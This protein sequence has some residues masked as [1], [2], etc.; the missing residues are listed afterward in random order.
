LTRLCTELSG[1]DPDD[2]LWG[3][4]HGLCFATEFKLRTVVWEFGGEEIAPHL[5]AALGELAE[6]VP[7]EIAELLSTDEVEAMRERAAELAHH[8]RLPTD[9]SGRAC[10]RRASAGAGD[11]AMSAQVAHQAD[12]IVVVVRA[13]QTTTRSPAPPS[14]VQR[15]TMMPPNPRCGRT[16]RTARGPCGTATTTRAV[17]PAP[18]S[19]P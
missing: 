6:A 3:I 16:P 4:D 14:A 19:W 18:P 17:R 7:A 15:T 5:L 13:R 12:E 1:I 9:P 2:A 8:R 11:G 10:P